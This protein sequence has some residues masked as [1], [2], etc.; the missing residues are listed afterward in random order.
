MKITQFHN[1]YIFPGG[2][3]A[4]ASGEAALLRSNGHEVIAYHRANKEADSF[5]LAQRA[6]FYLRDAFFS[7]KTYDEV[8]GLLARERPDIAH[9]HNAFFMIGPAAYQACFDAGV[10]VVQTLHNFRFLCANG[11][12]YRDGHPCQ[13][14]LSLGVGAGIRH[15]CWHDSVPAT[16][17]MTRVI[18]EYEKRGILKK[19]ARFIVLGEFSKSRFLAAGWPLEKLLVKPNALDVDPGV[20]P[21]RGAYVLYAGTFQSYKGVQTLLKAWA[22]RSWPVPLKLAGS[23]P[24]EASLRGL[25]GPGVEFLGQQPAD[26]VMA[27][28]RGASC[29]VV[30]S[31]CYENFPRVI[32]EA[33]ACGVPVVASRLGA[34]EELVHSGETGALFTPGDAQDLGR[35]L[36]VML[37]DPAAA[38]RMGERARAVFEERFTS[39]AVYRRMMDIYEQARR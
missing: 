29:V 34:M 22:A 13:D 16:F 39:G 36:D 33:Y 35:Q 10:P 18:G 25:N 6:G 32:L 30:P 8:R 38:G 21:Y 4:V 14:C 28:I 37:S 24:L 17:W 2:E 7:R 9:F 31:E 3:D 11:V 15:G 5:S 1:R 26:E 27:L 12:F 19:I 23:G 20:A